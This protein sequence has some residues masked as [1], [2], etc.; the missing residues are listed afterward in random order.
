MINRT[1]AVVANGKMWHTYIQDRMAE[2]AGRVI[3]G[4]VG[5]GWVV[6]ATDEEEVFYVRADRARSLRGLAG[7]IELV[8]IGGAA[9][10]D[11]A[12]IEHTVKLINSRSQATEAS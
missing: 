3:R 7:P 8:V 5:G 2:S 4:Q 1:V 10:V 6:I 12:E 9:G 11:W